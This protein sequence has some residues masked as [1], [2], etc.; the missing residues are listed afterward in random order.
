[1]NEW[2]LQQEKD[3][4][5]QQEMALIYS[6]DFDEVIPSRNVQSN[7]NIQIKLKQTQ[8]E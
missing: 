1:M 7:D 6:P 4:Q 8:Q 3:N 2:R 5:E